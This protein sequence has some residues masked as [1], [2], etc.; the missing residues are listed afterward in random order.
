M[1]N[2]TWRIARSRGHAQL[3]LT[4]V[5]VLLGKAQSGLFDRARAH[6]ADWMAP[7]LELVRT[8][9]ADLDRWLGSI[10]EIFNVYEQNLRL[11]EENA[12]LR[13]WRNAAVVLDERV[14]RYQLLMHAVPDPELSSVLAQVI[15]RSSRPFQETMILDAG[16][17]SG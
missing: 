9:L 3:P 10:G 8:P 15:G 6:V 12:R 7:G 5:I 13:Q 16:R 2:G 14:K 11:K 1:A 17:A 4:I